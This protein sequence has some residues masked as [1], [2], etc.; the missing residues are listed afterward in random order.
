M[1][2]SNIK[3]L[4]FNFD[5]PDPPRRTEADM[6]AEWYRSDHHGRA[7][8]VIAWDGACPNQGA[9]LARARQG[10]FYGT[11]HSHNFA[12]KAEGPCQSSDRA[13]LRCLLREVRWAPTSTE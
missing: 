4:D 6:A 7:R 3:L 2:D 12:F 5:E 11:G 13:E 10:A 9:K 8:M 1:H